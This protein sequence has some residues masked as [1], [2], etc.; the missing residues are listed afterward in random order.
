MTLERY[1]KAK[2]F[3][4]E[5]NRA[6]AIFTLINGWNSD[7]KIACGSKNAISFKESREFVSE[8]FKKYLCDSILKYIDSLDEKV[9]E[10]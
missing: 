5:K 7:T 9:G 3:Y 8:E 2:K 4:D 1:E 6:L 10:I